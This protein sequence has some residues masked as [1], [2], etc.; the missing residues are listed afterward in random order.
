MTTT[1]YSN[2][3]GVFRE[4][5][6]ADEAI[7]ALKQAGFQEDLIHLTEYEP[8][9]QDEKDSLPGVASTTRYIVDVLAE[10]REQEV[11]G[12]LTHHG[13][14]NADLPP[15]TSLVHG[16]IIRSTGETVDLIPGASNAAG[17]SS[18]D[19]FENVKVPGHPGEVSTI[20]NTNL[21]RG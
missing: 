3:V 20:D 8:Q 6:K 16:A 12:I 21:P 7:E 17:G 10:G 5:A 4:R 15:G 19:L 1:D 14:N 18:D 2:I 11:V 9:T 13:S